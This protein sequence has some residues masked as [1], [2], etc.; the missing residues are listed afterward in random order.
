M[1]DKIYTFPRLLLQRKDIKDRIAIQK[2]DY[3]IWLSYSRE[4]GF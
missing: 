4:K 3:G 2:K 1:E